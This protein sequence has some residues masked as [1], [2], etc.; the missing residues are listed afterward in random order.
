[1]FAPI[2]ARLASSFS[3]KGIRAAATETTCFGDTSIMSTSARISNWESPLIRPGT[4]SSTIMPSLSSML[5]W[6]IV[7]FASSMAEM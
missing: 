1:M 4:S 5:A 6:A 7:Y 3:R 2:R